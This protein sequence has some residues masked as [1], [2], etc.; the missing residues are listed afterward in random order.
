MEGTTGRK[1][2]FSVL[3][4][5]TPKL[6]I[7]GGSR[8]CV[9]IYTGASSVYLGITGTN[10]ATWML[11]PANTVFHDMF[12]SD[13]WWCSTPSSSGTVSGYSVS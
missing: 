4:T 5:T 2:M 13:A 8:Q 3:A 11:V 1:S 7:D 12:S 6:L 9:V 10:P